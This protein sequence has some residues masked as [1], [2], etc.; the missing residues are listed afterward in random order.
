MIPQLSECKPGIRPTRYNVLV[1][2][3]R[4]DEK[5]AGGILLPSKHIDREEGGADRGRV[6]AV[7]P[8]AFKGGDWELE[9]SPPQPGDI[10]HFKR[11][12]G[13]EFE[14]EDGGK[15][16]LVADDEIRGIAL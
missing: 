15:Y 9:T 8:M 5:T 2:I 14:G 6:V 12:S 4:V 3:E 16:R 10:V 13:A 7:S 1:A 11:Y